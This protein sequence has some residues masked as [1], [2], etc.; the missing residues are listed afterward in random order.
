MKEDCRMQIT[1][2]KMESKSL[3]RRLSRLRRWEES[4]ATCYPLPATWSASRLIWAILVAGGLA[5]VA[6]AFPIQRDT[7][8]NGLAL[9]TSED[10][11]IPIVDLQFTVRAG[12]AAD[13]AGQDGLANLVSTLLTRGTTTRSATELNRQIEFVGGQLSS[14]ADFDHTTVSINVLAKDLD[15]A[16]NLLADMALNPAFNDTEVT[17]A[18]SEII[19]QIQQQ[20]D[21]PDVILE[22]TFEHELFG[23][24]PYGHP[25]IGYDSTV[26]KLTRAQVLDFYRTWFVP[27]NCYI[28]AAG[29]FDTKALKQE[30]TARFGN[31]NSGPGTRPA[32]PSVPTPETIPA[33]TEP[34]GIVINRPEMNQA[35][36]YLGY[37]GIR[38]GAPDVFS[39]RLMNYVLGASAFGSR[40]GDAIR[41]K[42]GLAY[43]A[44]SYFD[45]RLLTGP[46]VASTETRTEST[47]ATLTLMVEQLKLMRDSGVTA[48]ELQ[49]AKDYYLGSFPLQ[50]KSTSDR[51]GAL[52]RIELFH[53]GLDYLDKYAANVNQ[54]TVADALK[55]AREHIFPD[56]YLLVIVGNLTQKD[57]SL[58]GLRWEQ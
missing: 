43:D 42:R 24:H 52:D 34:I 10:H 9:L 39:C 32:I 44:R 16:L 56:N 15:L 4:A 54:V 13:P 57:V 45:R 49:R 2:G 27:G 22:N 8:G 41:Q 21:D 33:I 14:A 47:Q 30:L 25:S 17:R 48:K 6:H 28:C 50:Y 46:F 7:L 51:L 31:W 26:A 36:V 53:L 20:A 23:S 29:D 35:H 40:I 55:A 38:E 11:H 58:P 18:R 5:T 1:E 37:V 3:G 19:G 12:S